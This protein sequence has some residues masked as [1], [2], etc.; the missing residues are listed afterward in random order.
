MTQ[1]TASDVKRLRLDFLNVRNTTSIIF[2]PI[3]IEDAVMQSDPFGSTPNWHIAHVTWFFQ[4]ILEKYKQNIDADSINTDYLNSY[5]Q[6]YRKI[7][8]K[9]DRGKFP[10]PK[11]SETLKYRSLIEEM[12]LKF[13]DNI[14]RNNS[15]TRNLVY[16]IELANQHEMQHQEL[17]IYDLQHYFQRFDDAEDNYQPRI[18]K[19]PNNID[20]LAVEPGMMKIPG[21]LYEL[22]F[23]GSDFCY[24][25]EVPE[26][27]TYLNAYEIDTYPVTNKQFM[28]FIDAGGYEDYRFWLSDGWDI[29]NEK[30]WDAPL[31]WQKIEGY[32]YKKD[33]G[34]LNKISPDEPVTNVSYYEADAYSKWAGK[35]IPTEAE[36]EKA[37]SWNEDLE[38]KTIYPWGDELP[39]DHTA[40]LLQSWNWAPCQIGSYPQGKSYYGCHQ[41]LGD[42]WEWTSSEYVLYPGFRSKFSEYTDKWAINQK[43][44]RGGSFATPRSQIRNSYRNYFK[45][46]ERIPFSGFRCVR[47]LL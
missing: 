5:Y 29:V 32:W 6:R 8:P 3:S 23:S 2:E 37:A 18:N 40:N 36:W 13:L 33:F 4:K 27:K 20:N 15:L 7:L 39:S 12:F 28:A 47:D 41:M 10:R 19:R 30:K 38:K 46:H 11:V 14:E 9:S 24:D 44:L 42:V 26:H 43:V 34:G 16:D 22:G 25:N 1:V 21:G 31:Y 17:L 35:R 45:P